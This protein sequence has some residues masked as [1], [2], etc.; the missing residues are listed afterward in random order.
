MNLT[1]YDTFYNELSLFYMGGRVEKDNSE[2]VR[3]IYTN[4]VVNCTVNSNDTG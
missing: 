2:R 3:N 4:V 1:A